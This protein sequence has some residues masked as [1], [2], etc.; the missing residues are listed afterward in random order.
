MPS[1]LSANTLSSGFDVA[2]S[3]RFNDGDSAY[4]HKTPGGAGTSADLFTFSIKEN[5]SEILGICLRT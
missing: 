5:S 3:C 1:I 2:N 4:M